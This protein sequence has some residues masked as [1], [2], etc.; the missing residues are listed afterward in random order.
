MKNALSRNVEEYFKKFLDPDPEADDVP[1]LTSSSLST[2]TSIC[3]KTF[4][5]ICPVV[6]CQVAS[7]QTDRQTDRQTN[8]GRYI[9]SGQS[10]IQD[11]AELILLDVRS[12]VTR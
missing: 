2:D 6:L 4:T 3:V 10:R 5:K 7:R 8:K 12:N 1:N 11:I 9:T